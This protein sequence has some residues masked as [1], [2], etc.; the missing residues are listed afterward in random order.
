MLKDNMFSSVFNWF[1]EPFSFAFMQQALYT[2]LLV[3]I[4]CALL[5]CYLVLKV[6]R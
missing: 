6:G 1:Y 4:V 5:S 3:S 2:A